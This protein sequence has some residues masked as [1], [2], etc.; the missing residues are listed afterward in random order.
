M[1]GIRKD[2]KGISAKRAKIVVQI[3]LVKGIATNKMLVG[4][5]MYAV[6]DME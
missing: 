5:V 1:S 3:S 2:L 4:N 6:V